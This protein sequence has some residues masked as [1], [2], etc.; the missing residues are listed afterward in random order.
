M[1]VFFKKLVVSSSSWLHWLMVVSGWI[2]VVYNDLYCMY[3]C[4]YCAALLCTDWA[5]TM[6]KQAINSNDWATA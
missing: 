4:L 3:L 5:R 2:C 6:Q 1:H